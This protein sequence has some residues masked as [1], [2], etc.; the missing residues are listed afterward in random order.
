MLRKYVRYLKATNP[1]PSDMSDEMYHLWA[2]TKSKRD[3]A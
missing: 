1:Q 2:V 3:L